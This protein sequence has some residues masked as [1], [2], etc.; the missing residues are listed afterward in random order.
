MKTRYH[1][2]VE[3]R[4]HP[5]VLLHG[6]TGDTSTMWPLGHEITGIRTVIAVDLPGHGATGLLED[7]ANYRF[8]NTV[9]ALAETVRQLGHDSVDVLGYSMGGRIALGLAVKYPDFV[10]S[11]ILIGATAGIVSDAE[12]DI[13]RR[14]DDDLAEE[15]LSNGLESFVDYWMDL[16]LFETQAR[17]GQDALHDA[18][19]QRLR[20]HPE[21]LAH[22][23]RGAGSGNQPSLWRDL[24]RVSGPVLLIVGDEDPKFRSLAI[25]MA[26]G[27]PQAEIAVLPEAGHAAHLENPAAAVVAIRTFLDEASA[28]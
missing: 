24:H 8:D 2:E 21:G 12:R 23:L 5:L 13:R 16:P 10:R 25:R 18:R 20:N 22:S 28:L 9:D 3:G 1:T 19:E 7:H 11:S 17:L 26:S 15:I 4:G 6:F 14:T 27:L